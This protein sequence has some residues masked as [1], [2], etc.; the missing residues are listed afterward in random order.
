MIK[1]NVPLKDGITDSTY[2]E[3]FKPVMDGIM[4]YYRPTAI[5]MQVL[6]FSRKL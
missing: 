1:V 6:S 4:K 2:H 3:V 5:V